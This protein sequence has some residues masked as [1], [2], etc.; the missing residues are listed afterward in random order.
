MDFTLKI[1]RQL[2]QSLLK[3]GYT[4]LTF[5]DFLINQKKNTK[6]VIL[7]HDVDLLPQNSLEFAKI[8]HSL[9]IR[10]SYYFR[11]VPESWNEEI[12]IEIDSLGHEIGYH[13][14]T[15]DTS[16]G[17]IDLALLQFKQCLKLLR[18]LVEVKT[19][20]MHGSPLSKYDNRELWKKFN[21]KNFDIL[22]EPYYDINFDNTYYLTDTGRRWDGFNVSVRDKVPQQKRWIDEG[23]IF[24]KTKE[25][26]TAIDHGIFPNQIMFTFHPQRWHNNYFFWS[27]EMILQNFKNLV[28][29][30]F[31]VR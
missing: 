20:C 15:M 17:N 1:Y 13:Y 10:G 28:K 23:F 14:E 29:K 21:Y 24:H 30:Y 31:Y 26:I 9:G 2:L 16:N 25:I 5:N 6:I 18:S 11:S 3:K 4:F 19:I 27:R 22:G 12:I 8:Q 7:R